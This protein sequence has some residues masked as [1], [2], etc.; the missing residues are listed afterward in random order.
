MDTKQKRL[1]I[2]DYDFFLFDWDGTLCIEPPL[3]R[4][5]KIINPFWRLKKRRS[6]QVNP[7]TSN[8]MIR[9]EHAGA[10]KFIYRR[11]AFEKVKEYETGVE[12]RLADISLLLFKPRL[13]E[14]AK[15]VLEK[16]AHDSKEIA[17]ISD[18]ALYRI[19]GEIENLGV[20]EYFEAILSLQSINRLKPDPLG[21]E[22]MIKVLGAKKDRVLYFGDMVD[23]IMFAKYAGIKSVAVAGG[24]QSY[25]R[26]ASYNPDFIFKSMSELEKELR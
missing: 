20:L 4:L 23:D 11:G 26:L 15:E 12:A 19:F 14:G 5:N 16:L 2:E 3:R 1:R 7:N 24:F 22:L 18:G 21:I 6:R 10:D 9:P 17:L 13:R 25:Y 8:D